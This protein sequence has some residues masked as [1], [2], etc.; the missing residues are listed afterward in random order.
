VILA[1]LGSVDQTK[2]DRLLRQYLRRGTDLAYAQGDGT[3][4]SYFKV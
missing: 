4:W 1:L 2:T 3:Q